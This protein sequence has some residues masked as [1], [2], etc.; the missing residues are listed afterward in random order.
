MPYLSATDLQKSRFA[1]AQATT[2]PPCRLLLMRSIWVRPIAPVPTRPIF[3]SAIIKGSF[4]N[5]RGGCP[6]DQVSLLPGAGRRALRT[7]LGAPW[8]QAFCTVSRPTEIVYF[9]QSCTL[10]KSRDSFLCNMR[11]FF[12]HAIRL[13][14]G[15]NYSSIFYIFFQFFHHFPALLFYKVLK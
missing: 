11:R 5:C 7:P 3:N 4:L 2:R 15:Q 13:F 12:L 8:S 1:S 6:A 14:S 9:L 10:Y